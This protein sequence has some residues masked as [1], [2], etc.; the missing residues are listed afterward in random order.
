MKQFHRKLLRWIIILLPLLSAHI[1]FSSQNQL[2]V[3][4]YILTPR[5]N[6]FNDQAM[7]QYELWKDRPV[8]FRT[9]IEYQRTIWQNFGVYSLT[10]FG[11]ENFRNHN[12]LRI[13]SL[14]AKLDFTQFSLKIGRQAIWSP[15][16]N[17]IYDGIDVKTGKT[18]YATLN[19]GFGKQAEFTSLW[20]QDR[21]L[22]YGTV[23]HSFQNGSISFHLWNKSIDN[24]DHIRTGITH[25]FLINENYKASMLFSWDFEKGLPYYNRFHITKINSSGKVYAGIRQRLFNIDELYSWIPEEEWVTMSIYAGKT[26]RL[27]EVSLLN[28]KIVKRF[29]NVQRLYFESSISYGQ[30]TVKGLIGKI[31]EKTLTGAMVSGYHNLSELF[32]CGGNISMNSLEVNQE[33]EIS[34]S[35]GLHM[36]TE[37]KTKK[38]FKF[39]LFA[40]YF[41]NP[42]YKVDGRGG[43]YIAYDI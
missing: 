41:D 12:S 29:S 25:N 21:I 2:S 43:I 4:H 14:Y 35:I 39:R 22:S 36:W 42:Y 10:E 26:H 38:G 34:E 30:Y 11:S 3:R 13:R 27:G 40:Q 18:G 33:T 37:L 7:D 24:T 5:L 28:L 1:L 6:F 20:N 16:L 17:A 32:S 15:F 31:D 19:V 23:S 9:D 8:H